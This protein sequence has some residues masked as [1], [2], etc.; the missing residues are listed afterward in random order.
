MG[1][2][3]AQ[4]RRVGGCGAPFHLLDGVASGI[5][6]AGGRG[7]TGSIDDA[8]WPGV[9]DTI[10]ALVAEDGFTELTVLQDKPGHHVISIR[11]PRTD[12]TIQL[13]TKI[14]TT[15]SIYGGASCPRPPAEAPARLTR[16]SRRACELRAPRPP[17]RTPP[18]RG[19]E[20]RAASRPR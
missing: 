18:L 16:L 20:P 15:L 5:Y 14:G 3:R 12:A 19:S 17:R 13:G 4:P 2:A 11:D 8:T 6:K 10:R 7:A 1:R 9:F